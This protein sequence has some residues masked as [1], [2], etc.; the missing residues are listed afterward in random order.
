MDYATL[1]VEIMEG[2]VAVIS[3]NRSDKRNAMNPQFHQ[4]MTDVLEVLRYDESVHVLVLT[5]A[6]P[7]FCAGMDLKES[8]MDLRDDP[9]G[10]DR[11]LRQANEWRGRTLRHYPKPVISMVNG[12]CFGAA[13]AIVEGCDLAF[14]A[15][16][17]RFGLSEIN[18]KS[19]PGGAAGKAVADL[20]R[21]RDALYYAMTGDMFDGR[22]AAAIG[23][24]NR[25][26]PLAALRDETLA[27]ARRIAGKDPA[28]LRAAKDTYRHSLHMDWDAAMSYARAKEKELAAAQDDA[29]RKEGIAGFLDG[30]YKPGLGDA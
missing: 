26:F 1:L 27:I 12:Y 23:F 8:I 14:A 3:F 4:D 29:Y 25:A 5:G 21:P 20:L 11:V 22:E 19:F 6:G 10:Y 2:G 17:A 28:A 30:K 24:V 9:A 13:F 15:E 18:F 7:A 16:E